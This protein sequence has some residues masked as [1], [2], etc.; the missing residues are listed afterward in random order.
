MKTDKARQDLAL[1]QGEMRV[2]YLP[3]RT[4]ILGLKGSVTVIE[5]VDGLGDAGFSLCVPVRGGES[6]ELAYGGQVTLR[7]SRGASVRVIPPTP[8]LAA[9]RRRCRAGMRSLQRAVAALGRRVAG[10]WQG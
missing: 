7:A 3:R 9:W 4:V 2:V 5:R 8:V 6:H 10:Q 1:C